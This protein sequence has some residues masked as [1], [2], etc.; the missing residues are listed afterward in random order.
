MEPWRTAI[1]TYDDEHIWVRGY[2]VT[3]L[4][5]QKTFSDTIFLLHQARLP[6]DGERRLLDAILHPANV[7]QTHRRSV[8]AR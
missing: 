4:M 1:A 3:A 2:D 5:V 8:N 6:N 7:P